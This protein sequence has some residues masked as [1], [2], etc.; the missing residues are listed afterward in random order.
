[1]T[2]FFYICGKHAKTIMEKLKNLRKQRGF[3]QEYMSRIISTDTSNYSRKENG[4][5]KIYDEEWEKLA[6]ALGVEVEE[7]KEEKPS[8]VVNFNDTSTNSGAF[9]NNYYNIPDYI[10]ENQQNYIN[11][12]KEQIEVLK[13][14]NKKL[15][16]Q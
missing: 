11:L 13:E 14:E 16:E 1:M 10:L 9:L 12:L 6:K 7:I 15:K 2:F 4:D 5:V 8:H 3:S